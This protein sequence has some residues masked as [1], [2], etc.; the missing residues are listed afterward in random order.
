MSGKV[1]LSEKVVYIVVDDDYITPDNPVKNKAV[2][3]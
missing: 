2:A 1:D 3:N